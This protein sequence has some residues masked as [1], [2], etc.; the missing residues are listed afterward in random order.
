MLIFDLEALIF[1]KDN[2][3]IRYICLSKHW[4]CI[5]SISAS[6]GLSNDEIWN[7]IH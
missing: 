2:V 6:V 4:A 1:S 3:F 7:H 5:P